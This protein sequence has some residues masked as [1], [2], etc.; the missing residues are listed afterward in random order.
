MGKV[1]NLAMVTDYANNN[2]YYRMTELGD[3]TWRAEYGRIG[4]S[5]QTRIY[6]MSQWDSKYREKIEKIR[7]GYT[8]RTDLCVT[9][10]AS[11][12]NSY[13]DI[14]VPSIQK[15]VD[16]LMNCA[17]TA[18]KKNYTVAAEQVTQQMVTEAQGYIN[19]LF[20]TTDINLFNRTLLN[21]YTAL[22]RRMY[23]VRETLASSSSDIPQILKR[24]QDLLDIMKGQVIQHITTTQ[25]T[26]KKDITILEALGLKIREVSPREQSIILKQLGRL[27]NRYVQAWRV[28]N[29]ATQ[30][31]YN[32]YLK[33]SG[34]TN[35][36]LLWHGSR[37]ENWWS[38][39]QTGLVLNPSAAI[40]GKMFGYGIY[41]APSAQKSLGYTSL[42]G[43]YWTG[44]K[45][46]TGYMALMDVAYGRPMDVYSFEPQY[47]NLTA[48]RL[49]NYDCLH[50]H[51]DRGM[52]RNDEIV[53]YREEQSTIK[54][55]VELH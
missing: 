1:V 7:K 16:N 52:L 15:L 8:D 9:S 12:D 42:S 26:D 10:V 5:P 33:Q 46:T 27:S 44:G 25:V 6:P 38:I 19:T 54:F 39:L 34:I 20:K 22:P 49:G 17:S 36:K 48:N 53:I 37:T 23:N 28:T 29:K 31:R 21:L 11:R 13:K 47:S 2:K 4:A 41:Y 3:G 43:A 50:A 14:E 35:T 40:T 55:L 51:K 18:V 32:A 45:S 24:E 30:Q